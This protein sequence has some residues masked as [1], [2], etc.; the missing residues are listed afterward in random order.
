MEGKNAVKDSFLGLC[1][2]SSELDKNTS[3]RVITLGSILVKVIHL[4]FSSKD[5][6]K[7]VQRKQCW[8]GVRV[9]L[10]SGILTLFPR[11]RILV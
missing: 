8:G 2:L 3:R 1:D 7:T 4:L 9:P 6:Q 5:V 11:E 10:L